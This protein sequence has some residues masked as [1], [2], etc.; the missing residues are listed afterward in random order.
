MRQ[1]SK[2]AMA[3]PY[4]PLKT[5]TSMS[6]CSLTLPSPSHV[7]VRLPSS[8]RQLSYITYAANI[9]PLCSFG[10]CLGR[11]RRTLG[12]LSKTLPESGEHDSGDL[13]DFARGRV[14]TSQAQKSR[15]APRCI[16]WCTVCGQG[17]KT[18]STSTRQKTAA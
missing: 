1:S 4:P 6:L 8:T 12:R 7:C 9:N 2:V 15:V 13:E 3:V 17:A 16:C 10:R 18:R 5:A 14:Y 11:F